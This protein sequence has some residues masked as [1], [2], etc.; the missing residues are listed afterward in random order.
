[1]PKGGLHTGTGQSVGDWSLFRM[2]RRLSEWPDG[3]V[4]SASRSV[5]SLDEKGYRP[6]NGGEW[7]PPARARLIESRVP[8]ATSAR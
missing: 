2:S 5:K 4:V 6:K 1:M 3:C 7:H 8:G